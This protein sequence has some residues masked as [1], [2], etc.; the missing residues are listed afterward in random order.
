MEQLPFNFEHRPTLDR[1]DFLVTSG[2]VEAVKMLDSYPSW[3]SHAI[4]IYGANGCGKTHLAHVFVKK[5]GGKTPLISAADLT[6]EQVPNLL[7]KSGNLV[8]ED[9]ETLKDEE[10][11]LHLYNYAKE[12]GSHLLMTSE[13]APADLAIKL[14]DLSSRLLATPAIRIGNPDDAFIKALLVK[15]FA[16]RQLLIGEEA[17]DYAIKN[18][19]RSFKGAGDLVAAADKLSLAKQKAITIPLLR[20]ILKSNSS[21]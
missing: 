7:A 21:I 20:E 5:T 15:L 16:D 12:T 10:A 3:P 2:N 8:V 17:I 13:V 4:I 14:P 19:E 1:E 18:M 6:A 9:M 11:L